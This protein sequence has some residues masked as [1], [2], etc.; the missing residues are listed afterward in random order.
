[1][2]ILYVNHHGWLMGGSIEKGFKFSSARASAKP[3]TARMPGNQ[4]EI[5][6]DYIRNKMGCNVD[7]IKYNP[8]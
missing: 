8:V 4:T 5:I 6:I 1:M 2:I 3:F 7:E